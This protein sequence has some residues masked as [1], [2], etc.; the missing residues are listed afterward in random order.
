MTTRQFVLILVVWLAANTIYPLFLNLLERLYQDRI[1]R[2]TQGAVRFG[3]RITAFSV[4]LML[5]VI[6][7]PSIL[8][9]FVTEKT[10][11]SLYRHKYFADMR[12]AMHLVARFKWLPTSREE[13]RRWRRRRKENVT[14]VEQPLPGD[15]LKPPPEA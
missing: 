3:V 15:R 12:Y 4:Q 5:F 10:L 1:D 6:V 7:L 13:L 11:P 2:F 8:L 9:V 14:P